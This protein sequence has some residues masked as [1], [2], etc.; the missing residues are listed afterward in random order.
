MKNNKGFAIT[1][2][3][4]SMIILFL[5]LM[6]LILILLS[7]RKVIL[8]KQKTDALNKINGTEEQAKL[9]KE[10]ILNGA[11]PEI[12][13]D[14]IAVTIDNDGTVKKAD[15]TTMWYS[16]EN[17]IWANAV[18]LNK[19]DS[20]SEGDIIPE[21]DIESYFVW[22]PRYRYKIFDEGNYTSAPSNKPSDYGNSVQTIEIVFED[23]SSVK[24]V[25]TTENDWLTHPAFTFGNEELNGIWVGKFETSGTTDN[26]KIKPNEVSLR[27]INIRTM[28][29]TSYNY[30]RNLDSHMMKNIE[31]GAAAYLS[32][33]KYGIN[34]E[35]NVNNN[36][37][38]LTGYS[39]TEDIF[40]DNYPGTSGTDESLTKPYNTNVGYK[41]STTGNISGIY[42]MSGGAREY[43]SAYSSGTLSANSG[44]DETSIALYDEKYF[45]IYPSNS[46]STT[47]NNRKLGDA[48]GE[49][50]P[51]YSFN[52]IIGSRQ[53]DN[54]YRD[55]AYFCPA[56]NW[57]DRG[58]NWDEA[59]VAGQ[60][61]FDKR[62]G[63]A[64]DYISFRIVLTP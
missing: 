42:D 14:L 36:K 34:T 63:Q 13:G 60:F 12:Y 22:I 44:F 25:G 52:D 2:I 49:M 45:D 28:F 51:F 37:S 56:G 64:Y 57:F 16:Y 20:Y 39:T 43:V 32:H 38:Y 1:S 17:K 24:S 54:W 3:I 30:K 55:N 62:G 47:Y 6:L 53:H 18:I 46:T 50:G 40:A 41:A 27:N 5:M 31:W 11:Y 21:A 19:E 33:S 58:G 7:S 23:K 8:D 9:Y 48:T 59:F 26:I 35:V 29:E 10:A 61:T 4:Y 15:R